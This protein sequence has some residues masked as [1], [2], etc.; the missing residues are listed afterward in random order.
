MLPYLRYLK[1]EPIESMLISSPFDPK[2][3]MNKKLF[4]MCH[5]SH[6]TDFFCLI[7]R[8]GQLVADVLVF[9]D[10]ENRMIYEYGVYI[11]VEKKMAKRCQKKAECRYPVYYANA[12]VFGKGKSL[13]WRK[14]WSH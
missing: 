3:L 6:S 9:A 5:H 14:T 10:P 7:D 13:G 12:Y 1:H 8:R 11:L 4:L 2:I